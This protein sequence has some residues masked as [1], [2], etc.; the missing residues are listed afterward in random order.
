MRKLSESVWMDIH[1]RSNKDIERKENIA[2]S[3][4]I[5]GEKWYFTNDFWGMG[6]TY[7]R[8]YGKDWQ[9]F[10]F[11]KMPDGS[12]VISGDTDSAGFFGIKDID[13]YDDCDVYALRDYLEYTGEELAKRSF[14]DFRLYDAYYFVQPILEKYI[15]EVFK[16]HMSEYAKFWIDHLRA[17]DIENT[18]VVLLTEGTH[19]SEIDGIRDEFDQEIEDA[20]MYLFPDFEGWGENLEKEL[21]DAY[22]QHG[23]IK[24]QTF[25]T[26]PRDNSL[27]GNSRNICFVKFD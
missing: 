24:S 17:S 8:E 18:M 20:N 5:D 3:C 22:E 16:S 21:T 10:A 6:D 11:Y 23:W 2:A 4:V 27:P 1:K 14:D 19:Y 7:K 15:K 25:D 13:F 9:A 12:H 26:D